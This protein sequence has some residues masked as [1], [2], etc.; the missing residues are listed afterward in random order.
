MRDE[1]ELIEELEALERSLSRD[2][3]LDALAARLFHYA[4]SPPLKRHWH[5]KDDLVLA[6]KAIVELAATLRGQCK[7]RSMD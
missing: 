7:T 2:A 6:A 4:D 3:E 1:T 5:I